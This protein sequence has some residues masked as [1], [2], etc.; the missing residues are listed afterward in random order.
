M[1]EQ[2]S[3]QLRLSAEQV[4]KARQRVAAPSPHTIPAKEVFGR[5]RKFEEIVIVSV[6]HGAQNRDS[7]A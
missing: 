6:A 2:D 7:D 3:S 5:F 4:A 1:E